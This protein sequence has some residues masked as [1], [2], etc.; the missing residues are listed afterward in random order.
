MVLKFKQII[1]LINIFY[2]FG[3]LLL[4]IVGEFC[5]MPI[6]I[7]LTPTI[8]YQIIHICEWCGFGSML[9]AGITN[10]NKTCVVSIILTFLSSCIF[11]ALIFMTVL[12]FNYSFSLL[13]GYIIPAII[14]ILLTLSTDEKIDK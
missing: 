5:H 9:L 13:L 14:S 3:F 4:L 2:G 1:S 10:F 7:P 8:E 6:I 12:T 11:L